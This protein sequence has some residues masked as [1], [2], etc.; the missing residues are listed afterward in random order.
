MPVATKGERRVVPSILR[1]PVVAVIIVVLAIAA[2]IGIYAAAGSGKD[3]GAPGSCITQRGFI[4]AYFYDS[5]IWRTATASSPAPGFMILDISGV[6]AGTAPDPHFAAIV[7]RA[8][9]A[10]VTIL[11]YSSTAGASRPAS[12]VEADVRNYKDWYGVTS[13]LLDVVTGIP[14]DFPYYR[15]LAGYIHRVD[16][17]GSLWL[18][19]GNYPDQAYA[20]IASVLVVFEGP[21]QQYGAAEVPG[22]VSKYPPTKFASTIYATPPSQLGKMIAI[23]RQRNTGFLYVTSGSGP[24]P[25]GILPSYWAHEAAELNSGCAST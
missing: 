9:A 13:I 7:R 12:E 11:G 4:P 20:S 10:G 25:Y 1:P 21:Y 22:W 14:S 5:G 17:A 18:N 19:S 16:P 23:S 15:T 24:N 2:G 8:R 3:H 6:G